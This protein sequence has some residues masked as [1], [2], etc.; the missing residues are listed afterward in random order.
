MKKIIVLG[1]LVIFTL[2]L[3]SYTNPAIGIA[4]GL[5]SSAI[6]SLF[7]EDSMNSLKSWLDIPIRTSKLT[8]FL[9]G[10]GGSGKTTF[11]KYITSTEDLDDRYQPSTKEPAYY[12]GEFSYAPNIKKRF[13]R[14]TEVS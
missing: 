7:M 2:V 5:L 14:I 4:V 10:R 8:I 3:A 9:Y 12:R 1:F 6:Y 13:N 11:I